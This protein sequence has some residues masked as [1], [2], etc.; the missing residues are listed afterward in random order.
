MTDILFSREDLIVCML[1]VEPIDL[2]GIRLVQDQPLAIF[3]QAALPR[4]TLVDAVTEIVAYTNRCAAAAR[5]L[6]NLTPIPLLSISIV[7]YGL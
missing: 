7:E 1:S 2:I 6:T 4:E 3:G 5:S